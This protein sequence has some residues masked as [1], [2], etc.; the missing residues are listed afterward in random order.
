MSS[1][2]PQQHPAPD[3]TPQRHP[4]LPYSSLQPRGP[5]YSDCG[6]NAACINKSVSL[7]QSKL[8]RAS[9]LVP[10]SAHISSLG[11]QVIRAP[12]PDF[13][14]GITNPDMVL[15]LQL[16]QV[17]YYPLK[18]SEFFLPLLRFFLLPEIL[19]LWWKRSSGSLQELA[20]VSITFR[21]FPECA[22]TPLKSQVF[23]LC[24]L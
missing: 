8:I 24:S 18:C 13:L 19:H 12:S 17:A 22:S 3:P 15:M 5:G 16:N 2:R 14:S 20:A 1:P 23:F 11:M 4:M 21:S 10:N 7:D 6:M 9:P